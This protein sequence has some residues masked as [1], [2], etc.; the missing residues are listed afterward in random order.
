MAEIVHHNHTRTTQWS[1]SLSSTWT[2]TD[3]VTAS[4]LTTAGFAANDEVV[5]IV[6]AN[7]SSAE[8]QGGKMPMFRV[9][10]NGA[11]IGPTSNTFPY[12]VHPGQAGVEI[13]H[14]WMERVDLGATVQ[15]FETQMR[16]AFGTIN[17]E[18]NKLEILILKADDL[19]T[20]G[21]DWYWNQVN[22]STPAD[23]PTTWG[24]K[25]S[26]TFTPAAVEDW[27]VIGTI[28]AN[29]DSAANSYECRLALDGSSI[30]GGFLE[31]PEHPNEQKRHVLVDLIPSLSA[32]SHTIAW[33][34]QAA[35]S[36]TA[37]HCRSSILVFKAAT[38][39]DVYIDEPGTVSVAT[40]TDVQVATITDTLSTTQ[41]IVI[42]G[43]SN[44]N[45]DSANVNAYW[46]VRQDGTTVIEPAVDQAS[47]LSTG[48]TFDPTDEKHLNVLAYIAGESGSLDLDLFAHHDEGNSR[49]VLNT[50]FIVWGMELAGA[51]PDTL[52]RRIHQVGLPSHG[53]VQQESGRLR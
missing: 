36:G 25:A 4:S 29:A 1:Q 40:G 6:Y 13:S 17:Q 23:F 10:Y 9:T 34:N 3:T 45:A 46:W 28:H 7:I 18:L 44:W 30:G 48:R 20:E 16:T 22:D 33:Q 15:D 38:F 19:G 42:I 41:N 50:K 11:D 53:I 49:D 32:A 35:T 47:G 51:A 8:P 26:V 52:P 2:T 37:A 14:M 24:S 39:A 21:T 27:V 31:E 12:Q 5:I 43:Q